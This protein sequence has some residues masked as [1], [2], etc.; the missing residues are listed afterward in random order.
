MTDINQTAV[1][2]GAITPGDTPGFP[3]RL[4]RPGF[5]RL[6]SN[7]EVPDTAANAIE[8]VTGHVTLDLNGYL[9]NRK[10]LD[11]TPA[12]IGP[13]AKAKFV[14]VSNGHIRGMGGIDLVGIGNRVEGIQLEAPDPGATGIRLGDMGVAIG[15]QV[16]S[17]DT[18]F[19][20]GKNGLIRGNVAANCGHGASAGDYSIVEGNSLDSGAGQAAINVGN[21]AIVAGNIVGNNDGGI[22]AGAQCLLKENTV[23]D[24]GAFGI[25]AGAGCVVT[26]N[27]VTRVRN[28]PGIASGT[29]SAIAGNSVSACGVGIQASDGSLIEGSAVVNCTGFG[30][31]MQN[32]SGYALNVL[33]A[34]NGGGAQVSGG[35]QV[36]TNE[37]N[38][39][40][41][42]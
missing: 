18:A 16:A 33:N 37:C 19:T 8:I 40:S 31:T 14:K 3:A 39:T 36:D 12:I 5:Y 20:V 42:P 22:Q 13:A 2:A 30:L 24:N 23:H 10:K 9:I 26:G 6:T 4:S 29:G 28:G 27:R 38:G 34:N 25:G 1:L 32:T 21:G 41:C 17:V 11:L 15:N 7:L 35:F